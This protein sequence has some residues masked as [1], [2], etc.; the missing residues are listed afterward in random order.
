MTD[1]SIP[2][3]LKKHSSIYI[4]FLSLYFVAVG[5]L[6]LWGYWSP[7]GVNI[8]E[9]LSLTDIAKSTAY[10]IVSVFISL[11]IGI[12]LGEMS[13]VTQKLPSGGGRNTAEGLFLRKYKR[14]LG[15]L[16]IAGTLALLVFGPVGKW[17][18]LPMLAGAPIALYA[19]GRNLL[20]YQIPAEAPRSVCLFLLA[21][22]PFFAFG[23]GKTG[24][25]SILEGKI[26]YY[27]ID[28]DSI[29]PSSEPSQRI[30]FIGHAGDFLFF[31]EPKESILL[32]SKFEA[33]KTLRLGR[34]ER[35]S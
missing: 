34:F 2:E 29:T 9:Y 32:I 13:S 11:A 23:L 5:S 6:Y 4:Y 16:Y 24:A 15:V 21:T 20:A 26:F 28:N 31:W 25:N 3:Q 12:V 10:P 17:L 30:R 35:K 22:L 8:L 18:V 19:R 33:G 27:V 14:L 7:F 1:E